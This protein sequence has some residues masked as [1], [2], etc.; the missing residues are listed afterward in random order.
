MERENTC[1]SYLSSHAAPSLVSLQ[2]DRGGVVTARSPFHNNIMPAILPRQVRGRRKRAVQKG[3]N[4]AGDSHLSR[5]K[6]A[7]R[8]VR[9]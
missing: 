5:P 8:L 6:Q 9:V 7:F 3:P 2:T 4:A 1:F